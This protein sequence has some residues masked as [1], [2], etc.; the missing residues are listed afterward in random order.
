[1]NRLDRSFSIRSYLFVPSGT[2]SVKR[3]RLKVALRY[4][5]KDPESISAFATRVSGEPLQVSFQL[6]DDREET[7]A[8]GRLG[9]VEIPIAKGEKLPAVQLRMIFEGDDV[10]PLERLLAAGMRAARTELLE[11]DMTLQQVQEDLPG[12]DGKGETDADHLERK[13][14]EDA[15]D[16]P[17]SSPAP[18][19]AVG[20]KSRRRPKGSSA[21]PATS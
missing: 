7:K 14:R 5:G 8:V 21:A 17:A 1:M 6:P 3:H 10:A 20:G 4:S 15:G 11:L 13:K 18:L 16:V 19:R 12:F 9:S 2:G